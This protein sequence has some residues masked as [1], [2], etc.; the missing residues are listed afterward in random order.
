LTVS[1][2]SAPARVHQCAPERSRHG[3]AHAVRLVRP[4]F[5]AQPQA[6]LFTQSD[7]FLCGMLLQPDLQDAMPK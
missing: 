4:N 5:L 3:R 6:T 7:R 1:P 2:K